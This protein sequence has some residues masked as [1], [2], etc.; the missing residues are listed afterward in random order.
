MTYR[1]RMLHVLP[2]S[3]FSAASAPSATRTR[4]LLLRRHIRFSAVQT[5][6]AARHLRPKQPKAVVPLT[7]LPSWSLRF[8]PTTQQDL[9][10]PEPTADSG[11]HRVLSVRCVQW[12]REGTARGASPAGGGTS[13][14]GSACR[15][16]RRAPSPSRCTGQALAAKL[17]R[18][19]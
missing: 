8:Y 2:G 17:V 13:R 11:V 4:D 15:A 16:G 6:E 1:R 12:I 3:T 7:I 5:R 9:R 14:G 18:G 19:R 10:R